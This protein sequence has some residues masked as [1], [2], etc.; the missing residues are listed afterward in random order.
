MA[1]MVAAYL[2]VWAVAFVFIVSM[3]QRQRTLQR[4]IETLQQLAQERAHDDRRA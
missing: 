4:D 3:V 2:I 1:Y